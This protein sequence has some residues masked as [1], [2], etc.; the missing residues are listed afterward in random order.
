[1]GA[2]ANAAGREGTD[3]LFRAEAVRAHQD[4]WLGDIHLATP[5]RRWIVVSVA[6]ILTGAIV[7]YL[8]LGEYTRRATVP[9]TLVP[10]SGLLNVTALQSGVVR[11]LTVHLGQHVQ[12]GQSLLDIDGALGSTAMGSEA[13]VEIAQLQAQQLKLQ[14]DLIDQQGLLLD[15]TDA[16][17]GRIAALG[18]Q[19]SEVIG[20]IALE[21]E[22]VHSLGTLLAK[23]RPLGKEG[24]VSALE[25]QQQQLADLNARSQL[26][27]LISQREALGEQIGDAGAQLAQLPLQAASQRHATQN[28]L[29]QNR[30]TLAQA[31][32]RQALVL[33]APESGV[34]SAL[35]I[36][37]GMSVASGETL[38][39]I[40]PQGAHLLAQLLVPSS[41]VGF[42]HRGET[43][44]L[45]YQAFPYQKYGLRHGRVTEVSRSALDPTEAAALLGQPVKVSFYRVLVALRR[46]RVRAYGHLEPLKAGMVLTANVMLDQRPLIDWI[47]E[48][49]LGMKQRI[50]AEGKA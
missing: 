38:L 8:F 36:K 16:L 41:A 50:D 27:S 45:R 35:V 46:Q 32:T 22:S 23:I 34:V 49:L 33:R 37:P 43:V 5:P 18:A 39:S 20:E 29:A 19:R 12:A 30:A 13:A 48:P 11:R 31:E 3:S 47:F 42:V 9:G 24:Y 40:V 17:R 26:K 44:L 2:A 21:R 4:A 14:A 7:A 1:M 10:T 25:I 15:Q 28:Q 6:L